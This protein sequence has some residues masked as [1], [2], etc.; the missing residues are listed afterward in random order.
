MPTATIEKVKAVAQELRHLTDPC[1][2]CPRLCR[3]KRFHGKSGFCGLGD[4]AVISSAM[5][6]FGE[7]PPITGESGSGTIFLTGC[8]ARCIFC[9][10]FQ[11][12][13]Q[14]SGEPVSVENLAGEF[15]RLQKMDCENVNWVTPTPHLV[16]LVEAL[17][18]AMENGFSL[19]IVYNTNGFDRA[20]IIQMLDGIVDIYL[21]DVKYSE[22]IWAEEF[23]GMPGY[24]SENVRAVREM[25]RQVGALELD[26]RGVAIRGLLVRHLVLPDGTAGSA[27][28]FRTIADIDP[29]IPVSIMAQYH[30]CFHA[31]GHS[32]VGR[33]IRKAEYLKALEEFE[34][35]GL[36]TAFT[37]NQDTLSNEDAFFPDFDRN[38]REI[39]KGNVR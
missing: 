29:A 10:N 33:R 3:A 22:D 35:A 11:I 32:I 24:V 4:T 21:P 7:E 27:K 23:S 31:V 6:H 16:F 38:E 15:L 18:V 2:I 30:P 34:L 26:E 39:F 1:E 14:G 9:Q 36:T 5:A 13:Q 12:S 8:N 37:Q 25:F 20:E 19:P 28:V 17:A